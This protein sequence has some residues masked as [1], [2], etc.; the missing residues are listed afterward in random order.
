MSPRSH[1]LSIVLSGALFC[2][3]LFCVAQGASATTTR[4]LV[5][6]RFWKNSTQTNTF[7]PGDTVYV[8]IAISAPEGLIQKV[9]IVDALPAEAVPSSVTRVSSVESSLCGINSPATIYNSNFSFD[10][11][12]F[13][14][15]FSSS[16]G[17]EVVSQ[18]KYFCYKFELDANQEAKNVVREAG[19]IVYD[20]SRDGIIFGGENNYML[21]VGAPWGDSTASPGTTSPQDSTGTHSSVGS[22]IEDKLVKASVRMYGASSSIDLEKYPSF[23]YLTSTGKGTRGGYLS[24]SPV[25]ITDKSGSVVLGSANS[26]IFYNPLYY[27]FG[28]VFSG[29]SN[30]TRTFDFSS[31][32]SAISINSDDNSKLSSEASLYG[33]IF[34]K[35]SLIYWDKTNRDKNIQMEQ[36]ISRYI[37]DPKMEVVCTIYSGEFDHG[38]NFNLH[39]KNCAGANSSP[40]SEEK[41]LYP[42]G[43]VWYY[44]LQSGDSP[45]FELKRKFKGKG[46][47]IVD[48]EKHPGGKITIS[49]EID[50]TLGLIVINGGNVVFDDSATKYNGIIFV[51]GDNSSSVNGGKIIFEADG[52]PVMIKG[53][54]VANEIVFNKRRKGSNGY[55]VEIYSDAKILLSL[56]QGFETFS[57]IV[58]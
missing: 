39:S 46:T 12:K 25:K 45:D 52:E 3:F 37:S 8:S 20:V 26:Y 42:A 4:A 32:N 53:S 54:L 9:S 35:N 19:V 40:T 6:K 43:R 58:Y 27:I 51:P 7:S 22:K 44:K 33:Y 15:T 28:N 41:S 49:K 1:I 38:G 31:R 36:N 57:S 30:L 56:L 2:F 16:G 55:A 10:N 29:N 21:I 23:L 13:E 14:A 50:A 5:E 34:D 47:L 11:L 48:F 17:I 24:Q 18:P